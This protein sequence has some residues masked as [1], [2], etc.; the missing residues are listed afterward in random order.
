MALTVQEYTEM[1]TL[2]EDIKKVYDDL[3][4]EVKT[5]KEE[6]GENKAKLILMEEKMQGLETKLQTPPIPGKTD[7]EDDASGYDLTSIASYAAYG[8]STEEAKEEEKIKSALRRKVLRKKLPSFIKACRHGYEHLN[9]DE[10]K[11]VIR[12]SAIDAPA[13]PGLEIKGLTISEDT[14]GGFF[15]P[16][17]FVPEIIKGFVPYS[18]MRNYCRVR[19]TSAR[20]IQQGKRT[21]TITAQWVGEKTTRTELTG[22]NLGRIEIPTNEMYALVLI[23]EQDL[24]D[25]VYDL[26]G[27][28]RAEISEQFGVAEGKA[29]VL[30]DA[31]ALQPQGILTHTQ[32]AVDKSGTSDVIT[33]DSLMTCYYAL[34]DPYA[35]RAT[36]YMRRA[37]VGEIR[38]LRYG[39]TDQ[40]Y[41]WEPGIAIDVP[42]TIFGAPVVTVPDM[43]AK[44]ASAKCIMV[45]DLSKAYVIVQRVGMTFKRLSE[46]WVE[47]SQV[48]IYARMRVGGQVVLPEAIRIYQLAA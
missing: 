45:G 37:T 20:S 36:W 24:E 2:W 13:I 17:E 30:G 40:R 12:A 32:I 1:R 29:F 44:G 34:P 22:Y 18:P 41:I 6:G 26:E 47:N 19:Q 9:A 48:G 25:P 39:T 10:R 21:G 27:E 38:K 43:P 7:E 11:L 28:I 42:G 4:L 46:R 14:T 16:P 5:F 15:A 31:G 35:A 23:S 3:L 33:T 8:L